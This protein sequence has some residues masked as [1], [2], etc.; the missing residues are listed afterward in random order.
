[1]NSNNFF[2]LLALANKLKKEKKLFQVEN[3]N[4]FQ[5]FLKF[6]KTV[7][8]NL[9]FSE[10]NEYINLSKAFLE[11]TIDSENFT[12]SFIA[13]YEGID[14][15]LSKMLNAEV[16]E[17]EN[18]LIKN[19]KYENLNKLLLEIYGSCNL[20]DCDMNLVNEKKLKQE[21]KDLLVEFESLP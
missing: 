1:M 20:F 15:K 21:V 7:S 14:Q 8:N 11:N 2:N 18:Y 3:P 4:E 9:H 10:K 5:L 17:L 12:Y 6:K 13:I 16:S 19:D